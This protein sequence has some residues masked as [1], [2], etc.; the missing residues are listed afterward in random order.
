MMFL[1]IDAQPA[2]EQLLKTLA[3]E[4]EAAKFEATE[5]EADG[6]R[7]VTREVEMLPKLIGLTGRE[8]EL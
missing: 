7:A 6:D 5:K 4:F 8:L 3:T 2:I 1:I